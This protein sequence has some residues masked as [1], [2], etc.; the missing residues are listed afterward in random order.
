M[1]LTA[2]QRDVLAQLGALNARIDSLAG[3]GETGKLAISVG[4]REIVID[5][6]GQ[7]VVE[8]DVAA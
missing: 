6:D 7:P 5:E 1:I 3:K 4:C 2:P 8:E